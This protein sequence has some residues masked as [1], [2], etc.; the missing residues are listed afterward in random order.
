MTNQETPSAETTQSIIGPTIR[1]S[2]C[3]Y[4]SVCVIRVDGPMIAPAFMHYFRRY[5]D[6]KIDRGI[7]FFVLD[8]DLVET[9]DSSGISIIASM[10]I[11]TDM[12]RG[13]SML[14]NIDRIRVVL[15]LTKLIETIPVAS[16]MATA[17]K[18]VLGE[19][20]EAPE[21]KFEERFVVRLE[22]KDLSILNVLVPDKDDEPSIGKTNEPLT[23]E[24]AAPP[25][26]REGPVAEIVRPSREEFS[27]KDMAKVAIVSLVVFALLI[28]GLVW[29]T[30]E[31]SSIP[32]LTLV[33]C[34]AL[35]FSLCLVGFI[36]RLSGH[37][38]EKT[39]EKLLSGVLSKI[40]GLGI[41]V[42]KAPTKKTKS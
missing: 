3:L 5:F 1:V 35:L 32:L 23:G 11:R 10:A 34:V 33:F 21:L 13:K 41:W 4:H 15:T 30:K 27:I 31:V 29:V 7:R 17:I 22:G 36:L 16:D 14:V 12:R 9:V 18:L 2:D 38:S 26:K 8:C 24:T 25:K 19:S 42:P 37:L 28:S 39:V 6:R 40:P 20:A